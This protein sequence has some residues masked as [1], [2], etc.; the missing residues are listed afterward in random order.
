MVS[1]KSLLAGLSLSVFC[2]SPAYAA[3]CREKTKEVRDDMEK[4][5]DRYT[6][7]A[8]AEA[9]KHLV[10]AELPSLKLADCEREV[11]KAKKALRDGK[12]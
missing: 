2:A 3:D 10:Q 6:A 1:M 9:Q 8:R 5:R 4:N 11:Q 7:E 12:K